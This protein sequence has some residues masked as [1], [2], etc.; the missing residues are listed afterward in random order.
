MTAPRS[1]NACPEARRSRPGSFGVK[2]FILI[3]LAL[4]AAGHLMIL[5]N[6]PALFEYLM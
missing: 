6:V 2:A 1:P 4:L 3:M 5:F